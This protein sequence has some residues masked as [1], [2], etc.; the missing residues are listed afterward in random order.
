[1]TDKQ[2]DIGP[3][4]ARAALAWLVEMGADEIIVEQAVDRFAAPVAAVEAPPR[5]P[6]I[7]PPPQASPQQR[8]P[9]KL[10][11]TPSAARSASD[12]KSVEEL[13]AALLGMEESALKRTASNL[14]FAGGNLAGRAMVVGD[15]AGREEDLEGAPFAGQNAALLDKMLSAIGLSAQAEEAAGAVS[16]FNLI[17]WRPPGNRPPTDAEV[18]DCLPYL[19]RAIEIVKPDFILCLGGLAAQSLL[20]TTENLM[21]MRGKWFELSLGGRSIP[22]ITTFPP[23]LLLQQRAQKRLAWRDLLSLQ[24]K[25]DEAAK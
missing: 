7:A 20:G 6:G 17:P 24:E 21:M 3:E 18:A 16:L 15:V 11:P 4:A 14:C 25:M 5:K 23:R 9:A 19:Q 22:L 13:E 12:C 2:T 10:Q 1:M 8:K